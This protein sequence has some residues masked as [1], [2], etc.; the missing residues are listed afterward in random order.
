M[1]AGIDQSKRDEESSKAR[2]T[3]HGVSRIFKARPKDIWSK[4]TTRL[5]EFGLVAA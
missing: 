4:N 1:A 3:H 2:K 5:D